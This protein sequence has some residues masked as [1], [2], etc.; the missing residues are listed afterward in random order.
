M[1]QIVTAKEDRYIELHFNEWTKVVL[2][3]ESETLLKL[4]LLGAESP[5]TMTCE[6]IDNSKADL[7]VYL[8][9]DH[10]EPDEKK[11]QRMVERMR[12]FKF[13]AK[14]KARYF[15]EDDTCYIMM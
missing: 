1:K 13:T 9:T 14:K 7:K 5:V 10:K 12:V 3:E 4:D 15:G 6:I 11:H 8:S 2:V